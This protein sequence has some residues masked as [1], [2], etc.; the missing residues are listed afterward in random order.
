MINELSIENFK[1]FKN[2]TIPNIKRINLIG[3]KNNIGKTS[4]LECIFEICNIKSNLF[5]LNSKIFRGIS[6]F[7]GQ[8]DLN[9]S[10]V[11]GCF[12]YDKN[13]A[14]IINLKTKTTEEDTTEYIINSKN[15]Q[16]SNQTNNLHIK[17]IKKNVIVF[18][19]N[20]FY[21][22]KFNQQNSNNFQL[23]L[24]SKIIKSDENFVPKVCKIILT[25]GDIHNLIIEEFGLAVKMNFENNVLKYL[26]IIEPKLQNILSVTINNTPKLLCQIEGLTEKIDIKELGDGFS[27]FLHLIL[28]VYFKPTGILLVDEIANGIHYS[29]YEQMW[30]LLLKI[31]QD[32]SVQIFATTHSYEMIKAFNN[33]SLQNKN[34][35]YFSY[36]EL[37]ENLNKQKIDANVLDCNELQFQ[38]NNNKPFRGE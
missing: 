19:N 32:R 20:L 2:L 38:L 22:H 17:V 31:A 36:I 5:F 21:T 14:N 37:F 18:E 30:Q 3:G 9:T 33:V 29:L 24:E 13:T 27:Q 11:W 28:S 8:N 15:S 7:V 35:T 34:N 23:D 16:N 25:R 26:Q 1:G 10:D 12:F 6:V 4:L